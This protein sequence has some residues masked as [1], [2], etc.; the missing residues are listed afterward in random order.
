MTTQL[1]GRMDTSSG[2]VMGPPQKGIDRDPG[3][4]PSSGSSHPP[5]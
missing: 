2:G 1:S 4:R 3:A 5:P